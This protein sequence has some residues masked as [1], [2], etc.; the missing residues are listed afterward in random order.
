MRY[1]SRT[2]MTAFIIFM[3]SLVSRMWNIHKGNFVIWD[4]AHFGKMMIF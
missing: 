2:A 4:E 3:V 1:D